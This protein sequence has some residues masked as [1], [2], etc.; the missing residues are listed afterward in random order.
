MNYKHLY[1]C[2]DLQKETIITNHTWPAHTDEDAQKR[3]KKALHS[4]TRESNMK[5]KQT[6]SFFFLDSVKVPVRTRHL[7]T[8]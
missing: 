4:C 5:E 2:I 1:M 8:G 6:V 7:W 3:N